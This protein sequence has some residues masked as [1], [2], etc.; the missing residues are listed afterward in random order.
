L[1]PGQAATVEVE[2]LNTGSETWTAAEDY[3]LGT[4]GDKAGEAFVFSG[5]GRYRLPASASV[6]PGQR[7][8]FRFDV[9]APAQ[10]GTYRPAWRMLREQVTWFGEALEQP[11]VVGGGA[12]AGTPPPPSPGTS[13]NAPL[14]GVKGTEFTLN[15][16]PTYLL[17]VSY[18]DGLH[19]RASD[20]NRL[21]N[22]GF[23]LIRIWLDWREHS[24]HG[25]QGK[26]THAQTL[27][28]L[29]RHAGSLGMV[30]DVTILDRDRSYGGKLAFAETAVREAAR[31]L[32]NEPNVFF[33]LSN[34]HDAPPHSL[35]HTEL[36]DLAKALR[37]ERPN[38]VVTVSSAG[39][40]LV[41]EEK[42][43]QG[44]VK[45]ELNQIGVDLLAPHFRRTDD[46]AK[47]TE[48]R[49]RDLL[50][51]AKTVRTV[52]VYVQEDQ[53]RGWKD[54]FPSKS[55][56]LTAERGARDGG[57]A[58][59]IFHTDAG[60]DLKASSFFDAL[61]SVELTVVNGLR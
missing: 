39:A 45:E 19:W 15:G 5:I 13:P 40:H 12:P 7:H 8:T 49:V 37:Q 4:V 32:L 22:Q 1:A 48:S 36:M 50:A 47:R 9:T 46:W 54:A 10:P 17:G 33:D 35:D 38:S 2:M 52:P 16:K 28:D 11:V 34:E 25:A 59:W 29:V 44:A 53:R 20:L 56:F 51:F 31:A 23:N 41:D 58:G 42:V 21:A 26:L 60:F 43:Q 14:V 27:V 30:V 18:F 3:K 55:E 57:A 6:A 24:F 61:D